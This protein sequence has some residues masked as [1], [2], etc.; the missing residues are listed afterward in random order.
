MSKFLVEFLLYTTVGMFVTNSLSHFQG[1]IYYLNGDSDKAIATMSENGESHNAGALPFQLLSLTA[2]SLKGASFLPQ[3]LNN[4]A[5]GYIHMKKYGIACLLLHKAL[6][7]SSVTDGNNANKVEG[8]TQSKDI[9][10]QSTHIT[11]SPAPAQASAPAAAAAAAA[12]TTTTTTTAYDNTLAQKIAPEASYNLGI[13][14]LLSGKPVDALVQFE[15]AALVLSKRPMLWMR[16]AECCI[17]HH[18]AT[19][20]AQP[21]AALVEVAGASGRCRRFVIRLVVL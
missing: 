1:R 21:V 13:S 20:E 7:L 11:V 18:L 3:Y 10:G 17:Q 9:S 4:V 2:D 19:R 8:G 14:L 15:Q 5:C 12:V 6:T 16:M